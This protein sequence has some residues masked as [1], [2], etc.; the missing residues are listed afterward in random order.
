[1]AT[2]VEPRKKGKPSSVGWVS[3]AQRRATHHQRGGLRRLRR[4]T[5]PS[6]WVRAELVRRSYSP[7]LPEVARMGR[8]DPAPGV[9]GSYGAV[10]YFSTSP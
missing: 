8:K 9:V 2:A 4:L 7:C 6:F 3:V 10:P 1:M 5:H